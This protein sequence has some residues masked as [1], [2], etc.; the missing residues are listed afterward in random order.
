MGKFLGP[1]LG[2]ASLKYMHYRGPGQGGK[3][4]SHAIAITGNHKTPSPPNVST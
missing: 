3:E 1:G 2:M 4:P